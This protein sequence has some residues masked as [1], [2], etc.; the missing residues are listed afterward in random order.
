MKKE[1]QI[2]TFWKQAVTSRSFDQMKSMFWNIWLRKKQV[3]KTHSSLFYHRGVLE[4]E[5]T[6]SCSSWAAEYKTDPGK[7][8]W[9][10]QAAPQCESI[11]MWSRLY[12]GK[13]KQ[14]QQTSP[15]ETMLEKK[16][17]GSFISKQHMLML[18]WLLGEIK[19]WYKHCLLET[20]CDINHV[21]GK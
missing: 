1:S 9:V 5:T 18:A 11:H 7:N 14:V 6:P 2:L 8:D 19:G 15:G 21:P 13:S 12:L 20:V 16:C 3:R 17:R 10:N 4:S